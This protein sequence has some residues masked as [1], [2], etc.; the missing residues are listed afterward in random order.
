MIARKFPPGKQGKI[1]V[2]FEYGTRRGNFRQDILVQT[3]E[4]AQAPYQ[5]S[6]TTEIPILLTVEPPHLLW[7]A[8]DALAPKTAKITLHPKAGS[9]IL[10]KKE[11][12]SFRTELRQESPTEYILTVIPKEPRTPVSTAIPLHVSRAQLERDPQLLRVLI[13]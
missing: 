5:L 2:T 1:T 8:E 12:A 3:D 13:R 4:P 7:L 11:A 6:L 9:L 10:G